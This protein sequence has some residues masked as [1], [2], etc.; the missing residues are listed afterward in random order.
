[1]TGFGSLSCVPCL[2]LAL[3][4]RVPLAHATPALHTGF[5]HRVVGLSANYGSSHTG[6]A[7]STANQDFYLASGSSSFAAVTTANYA[8]CACASLHA[9]DIAALWS[10]S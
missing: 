6:R 2:A 4:V 8:V 5:L 10:S 7:L 1:V 9:V 3:A